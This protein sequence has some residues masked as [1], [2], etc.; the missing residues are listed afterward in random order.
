MLSAV[1][2]AVL[3][4]EGTL[5]L[6]AGASLAG[7]YGLSPVLALA[8]A[9][10]AF[11]GVRVA[12]VGLQYLLATR[13]R[14]ATRRGRPF[15]ETLKG[16][17]RE[18]GTVLS[19]Y[20]WGQLL[21]RFLSPRDPYTV[22]RDAVP[23][24]LLVHGIYCNAGVWYLMRRRLGARGI[25][26]L[27]AINLEPPL[28]GIDDFALALAARVEEVRRRTGADKVVLVAHSMGGLVSRAYI[29]RLGG[30]QRVER[31]VTIGSPHHGSELARLGIGRC[32][33]DMIPGGPWLARLAAAEA[34]SF[35]VPVTTIFSWDDNMVAPQDSPRLAGAKS[36]ALENVGH[37]ELLRCP[38]VMRL[39]ADEIAAA[40]TGA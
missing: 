18:T 10:A 3:I 8:A 9:V 6:L 24:V 34:G 33:R 12:V 37:L 29:A 17:I 2:L 13:H 27:F 22:L 28:A 32:A 11:L 1:I 39:V 20:T 7:H 36:V 16:V 30:A 25:G 38:E 14:P 31:L 23:P 4:A 15:P 26:N 5:Y 40:R 19:V 21:Q 35:G